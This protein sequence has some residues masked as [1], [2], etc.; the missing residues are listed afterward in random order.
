MVEPQLVAAVRELRARLRVTQAQFAE[1]LGHAQPLVALWETGRRRPTPA[2]CYKMLSLARQC[3][4]DDLHDTFFRHAL[5]AHPLF[6]AGLSAELAGAVMRA[7]PAVEEISRL[8]GPDHPAVEA[9][10]GELDEIYRLALLLD[11]RVG[12]TGGQDGRRAV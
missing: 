8:A 12:A 1:R 3:G 10:S 2:E 5:A 11:P 6:A 9:V 7:A 4:W